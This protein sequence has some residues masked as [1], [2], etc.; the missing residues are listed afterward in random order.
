[1]HLLSQVRRP[2][3]ESRADLRVFDAR[4]KMA[5]DAHRVIVF[6]ALGG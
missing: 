2:G 6:G 4:R 1:M 5:T 3:V